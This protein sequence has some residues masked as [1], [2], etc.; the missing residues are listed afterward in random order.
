M[1]DTDPT[2]GTRSFEQFIEDVCSEEELVSE[3]V[4]R[5]QQWTA[6][7]HRERM[8]E[9]L[10]H[11]DAEGCEDEDPGA[12]HRSLEVEFHREALKLL[13][14]RG[15]ASL[16][17]LRPTEVGGRVLLERLRAAGGMYS[18]PD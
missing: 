14:E 10:T 11:P 2:P 17:E 12:E 1:P 15:V 18:Y 9:L 3:L 13:Y 4:A 8:A 5:S 6:D 16:S 7:R